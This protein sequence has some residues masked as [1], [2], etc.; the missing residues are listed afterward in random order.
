MAQMVKRLPIMWETGFNPR[1][2]KV[3]VEHRELCS[4]LCGSLDG[5]E[6]WGR[7]DTCM[8]ES[9]CWPP[10]T[11]MILLISYTPIQNEA[12][13]E[14]EYVVIKYKQLE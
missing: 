10:E 6:V 14:I 2:G 13:K 1:V 4:T 3:T 9:F 8:A 12:F 5:R 11:I 7:I